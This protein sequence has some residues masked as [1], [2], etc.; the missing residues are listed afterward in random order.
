MDYPGETDPQDPYATAGNGQAAG[1]APGNDAN[2]IQ[3]WY[4]QFMGRQ[5]TPAE[6]QSHLGNPGGL[7][8]VMNL[9]ANSP[10][11]Q[12]YAA[13]HQ[14]KPATNT[15]GGD[16][17]GSP[18]APPPVDHTAGMGA[19]PTFTPPGYTPPPAF[20]YADFVAPDPNKLSSDP[21]YQYTLK[22]EQDAIQKSAAARGVLNTGGTINDLLLNARDVAS[23][24]YQ[25]LFGRDLATYQTNRGNALDQY[26]T[27]YGTQYKDPYTISY[28]GANDA[29]NSGLHNYD[30]SKQYGWMQ[31]LFDFQQN[32]NQFDR[33]Y[34]LLQLT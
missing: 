29:F 21:N 6:I 22:T 11:A 14:A 3:G 20:S 24:G 15:G 32:Q 9:I 2:Q 25:G 27:N 30:L 17:G 18:P 8:A 34:Q 23:Q 33:Q 19:A 12:A 10:E 4:G 31:N 5:A 7:A 16:L 28:Q 26:N 1:P 13:A